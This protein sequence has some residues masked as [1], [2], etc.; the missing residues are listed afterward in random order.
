MNPASVGQ[1]LKIITVSRHWKVICMGYNVLI[2]FYV[3]IY[4]YIYKAGKK[5]EQAFK[6]S[7]SS[8]NTLSLKQTFNN[9]TF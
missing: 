1:L 3:Q 9:L 7:V 4:I 5:R 2:D 6:N 8:Q